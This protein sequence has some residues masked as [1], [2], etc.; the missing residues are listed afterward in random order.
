MEQSVLPDLFY[1][2]RRKRELIPSMQLEDIYSYNFPEG[3]TVGEIF[4]LSCQES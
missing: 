4:M 1:H 3:D 2:R